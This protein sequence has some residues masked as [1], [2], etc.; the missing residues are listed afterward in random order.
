MIR[1]VAT[2]VFDLLHL[3]HLHFLEEAKKLGDELI[4]IVARDSTAK[5]RKHEPI[6]PEDMRVEMIAAL[7]PVDRAVLG[8]E[9]DMFRII[10]EIKPDIIA[11][12]HDQGLDVDELKEEMK[13]RG[14]VVDIVR[15]PH[16]D[17]DI[18]GTRK[19]IK[20]VLD[21]YQLQQKLRS[22]EGGPKE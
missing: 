19:V 4:V 6:T 12:G 7:K 10:E 13:T 9:D 17:H 1:V 14:I 16:L 15:L 5:R 20:K 8:Y 11:L 18:N 3:G 21:W 2:G 22:V